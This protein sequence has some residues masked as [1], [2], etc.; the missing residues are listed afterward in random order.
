MQDVSCAIRASH[1]TTMTVF[2]GQLVLG[3]DM[4]FIIPYGSNLENKTAKKEMIQNT[5][6]G[7]CGKTQYQGS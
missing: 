4:S 1:H 7:G 5:T 3:K 6:S 2:P